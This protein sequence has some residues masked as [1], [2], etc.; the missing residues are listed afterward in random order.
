M[1]LNGRD[2]A[3]VEEE[4]TYTLYTDTA[5]IREIYGSAIEPYLTRLPWKLK[6][7]EIDE[8]LRLLAIDFSS[9]GYPFS[10]RCVNTR[11]A[12]ARSRIHHQA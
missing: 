4:H 2:A 10:E 1:K 6:L 8:E 7:G 12:D 11:C 5:T 9:S 3:M